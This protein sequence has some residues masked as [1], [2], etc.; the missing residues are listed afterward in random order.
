[1]RNF[2]LFCSL[3]LSS[4]NLFAKDEAFPLRYDEKLT[5]AGFP[6]PVID[7]VINGVKGIFLI[8]TGASINI[9]SAGFAQ[10]SNISG[11]GQIAVSDSSG[12][13]NKSNISQIDFQINCN[14]GQEYHFNKQS[15][16][17]VNL[18][19]VFN[20]NEIAGIISPQQLL[21]KDKNL[22]LDLKFP[23]MLITSKSFPKFSSRNLIKLNVVTS[24]GPNNTLIYLY[25]ITGTVDNFPAIFIADTGASNIGIGIETNV[26]HSL[27]KKAVESSEQIGG[28][29]GEPQ[30]VLIIPEA[31]LKIFSKP[32]IVKLRL[33]PISSGMPADGMIGMQFLRECSLSLSKKEGFIDCL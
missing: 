3:L 5:K 13:S 4:I 7:V 21:S 18:P 31:E 24:K 10:R 19:D 17:I 16:A 9:I 1:M 20:Q 25:T 2:I 33:Q 27:H 14:E 28:I 12:S 15:F 6:S 11:N 32:Q 22:I 30:K 29:N 23:R 8:D 26:G